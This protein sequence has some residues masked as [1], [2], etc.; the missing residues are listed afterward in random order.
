MNVR[1]I[2]AVLAALLATHAYASGGGSTTT[3]SPTP[4]PA[5][6][7]APDV[8]LRESFGPGVDPTFA[9][10][11]GGNGNLRQVFAGA[12]LGGFWL[13][14]PGSKSAQWSTPDV[15]PGWHFAFASL[16][17]YETLASPIQPDPFNGIAFS[18]WS[19]GVVSYPD[20]LV[21]FRGAAGRYSVSAELY[22]GYLDAGYAAIGLTAS[23]ALQA[24][25][26]ASGQIWVRLSQ[27]APFNGVSGSYEVR[28]GN[29]VLT[30][31][32]TLL[33]G[34]NPVTITVDP[35]AQTVSVTLRGADLGT[36]PAR[37]NPG[38]IAFEG[39]GWA[40]DLVVRALP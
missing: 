39:Q 16:N 12:G 38:Y 3:T 36:W 8:I 23:G 15:G 40:D 20:A 14:Y 1:T 2:A 25:L 28:I 34:F 9:R 37:V 27:V 21:P 17:P 33:D 4:L 22:P 29:Q 26:P 6:P 19:D 31:G 13:E 32:T 5:S 7:P 18:G 24:N 35:V 11:Q 10:P 30:S